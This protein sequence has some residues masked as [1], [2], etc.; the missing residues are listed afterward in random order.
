MGQ[1]NNNLEKLEKRILH[2]KSS[3]AN[4]NMVRMRE[5]LRYLSEAK[6]ELFIKIPFLIHINLP[7][8]PGFV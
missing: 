7:G 8:F 2:L 3:F 5:A 4:H 1:E 6:L